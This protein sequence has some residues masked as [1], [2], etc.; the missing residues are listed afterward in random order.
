MSIK[1]QL[2]K[3]DSNKII[4]S[5]WFYN[6]WYDKINYYDLHKVKYFVIKMEAS[7]GKLFKF[8]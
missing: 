1:H 5:V 6:N 4:M 7:Y 8:T 2:L 3:D